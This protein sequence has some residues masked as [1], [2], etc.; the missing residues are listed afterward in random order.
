MN[1]IFNLINIFLASIL[2]FSNEEWDDTF[3]FGFFLY[4]V[5][6]LEY[7]IYIL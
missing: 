1:I 5:I 4:L 7:F 2:V 6:E 3:I